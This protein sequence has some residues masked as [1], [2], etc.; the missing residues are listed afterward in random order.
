MLD[1]TQPT[2]VPFIWGFL[3]CLL[4]NYK[5]CQCQRSKNTTRQVNF[6]HANYQDKN[7]EPH[8]NMKSTSTTNSK[9]VW[10]QF[11]LTDGVLD[12]MKI[13]NGSQLLVVKPPWW[14][15]DFQL[16]G[17]RVKH[18][19]TRLVDQKH[20]TYLE[21]CWAKLSF[22]G[23]HLGVTKAEIFFQLQRLIP[24]SLI[25]SGILASLFSEHHNVAKSCQAYLVMIYE[26]C[27]A[28]YKSSSFQTESL[29]P[30]LN[31]L[32]QPKWLETSRNPFVLCTKDHQNYD[33]VCVLVGVYHI[34]I[35]L[36]NAHKQAIEWQ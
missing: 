19:A 34:K 22:I 13:L 11:A 33:S 32:K 5:K 21:S 3:I 12:L 7:L 15:S 23:R 1:K 29:G 14:T 24:A 30:S 36:H 31:G 20:C 9:T 2:L 35:S 28:S 10:I 17:A 26:L 6:P 25:N 16:P 18:R 4:Q 27:T 8:V